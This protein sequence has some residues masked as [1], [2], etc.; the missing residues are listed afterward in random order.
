M[1][2]PLYKLLDLAVGTNLEN[3]L[4]YKDSHGA[5]LLCWIRKIVKN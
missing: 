1:M 3:L 4:Q 2:K 5:A